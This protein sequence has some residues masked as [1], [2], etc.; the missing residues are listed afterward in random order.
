LA[1]PYL[2]LT[3]D[4]AIHNV[5]Q[6][7]GLQCTCG[8]HHRSRRCPGFDHPLRWRPQ[9]LDLLAYVAI[10]PALLAYHFWNLGVAAVG[11]AI[12]TRKL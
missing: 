1:R 12:A 9:G 4:R 10:F 8:C 6:Y 7:W 3:L 5:L 2:L 11:V